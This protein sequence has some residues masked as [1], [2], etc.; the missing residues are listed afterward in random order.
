MVDKAEIRSNN[1][2]IAKNTIMLYVRMLFTMGV[3]LYTS[4][5]VLKALGI[6]DFGIY[7]VVGGIITMFT[8]VNG[9]LLAATQRYITFEIGKGNIERLKSV[10]SSSLQIH[11]ILSLI[12]F[13][14]GETVGLWFL[15]NKLVIPEVRLFAAMCV[16]QCS[17]ISCIV[18]IMSVP[19]NA[20]I[21]AHEKMSA[22][23]YISIVEVTLK[24]AIVFLLVSLPWD[25]LIVYAVLLL[26]SQLVIRFIYA[27]YCKTHF[28]ES[29]YNNHFDKKLLKEMLC[30]AGWSFWGSVSTILYTQGLNILLNMFYGPIVNAA[31]GIA[32]QVQGAVQQFV[33]NFQMALN[34]QIT[35]TYAWGEIEQ[36]HNLM[37]RSARFSFFLLYFL[38]LP[39]FLELKFVLN[40]WLG[41]VPVDTIV[42][43]QIMLAIS[44]LYT[45]INPCVIANQAT[46]KVKMYQA[47]VG[48]LLLLVVPISYIVLKLGA[49]AYSVFIVHFLVECLAQFARMVILREQINLKVC[50]YFKNIYFQIFS[51]IVLSILLPLYVKSLLQEGWFRFILVGFSSVFSVSV[52]VFVFGFTK[53]ERE[54]ILHKIFSYIK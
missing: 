23:A 38:S 1:S 27:Y 30:F 46:G 19:Y 47:V 34:P 2:R 28:I 7:N 20:D 53:H 8:F 14:L 51:V 15:L 25:R 36:M 37:F 43:T 4:R 22:F 31:R 44:L 16:Y 3:T 48:G 10:F 26:L 49:P 50:Q 41:D 5:V 29:K 42:F 18:N 32:I 13:V 21:I 17:I 52:S 40:I 11:A 12:I 45:I 33:S 9:G 24:L 39:L 6:E 35:K 54:F